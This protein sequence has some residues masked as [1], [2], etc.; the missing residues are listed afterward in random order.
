MGYAKKN[1]G[2]VVLA[3]IA[4]IVSGVLLWMAERKAAAVGRRFVFGY[5]EEFEPVLI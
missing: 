5:L 2:A 1:T 4:I 3:G